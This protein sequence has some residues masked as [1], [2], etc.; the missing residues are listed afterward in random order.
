M[1]SVLNEISKL[2]KGTYFKL[3]DFTC[4]RDM[5]RSERISLGQ[6]FSDQVHSGLIS[7]AEFLGKDAQNHAIYRKV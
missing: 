6:D 2:P 4:F 5:S 7:K 3:S 1:S